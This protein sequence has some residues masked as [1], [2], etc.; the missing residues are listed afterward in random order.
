MLLHPAGLLTAYLVN[1]IPTSVSRRFRFSSH[2]LTSVHNQIA[3]RIHEVI[4]GLHNFSVSVAL[5]QS[6]LLQPIPVRC[7][8]FEFP[9]AHQL[10]DLIESGLYCIQGW[11]KIQTTITIKLDE[12][13][14]IRL[15]PSLRRWIDD[16]RYPIAACFN[17]VS[18]Q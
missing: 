8:H 4:F 17:S 9:C 16:A 18:V 15:G 13:L 12:L 6:K 10:P 3:R 1:Q 11:R 2:P 5:V 7:K 14:A